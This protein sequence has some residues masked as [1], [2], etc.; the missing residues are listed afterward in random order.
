[1]LRHRVVSGWARATKPLHLRHLPFSPCS[2]VVTHLSH[3][4]YLLSMAQ[5]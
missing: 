5:A 1:M 2:C 4:G 3:L